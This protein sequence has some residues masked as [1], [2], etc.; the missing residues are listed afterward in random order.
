MAA[1]TED[2]G[3]A[4][5]IAAAL[6]L[7]ASVRPGG[8]PSPALKRRALHAARLYRAGLVDRIIASGGPPG[9]APSE[10]EVIRQLCLTA[11]VEEAHIHPEPLARNTEENIRF[12]LP[13]LAERRLA[14]A[15]LVTDRFHARRAEMVARAYGLTVLADCPGPTGAGRWQLLRLH[16]REAAARTAFRL[17]GKRG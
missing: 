5:P 14:L 11:G 12:A 6:V 3:K 8:Q 15:C 4:R 17:R 9:A 2:I 13:V 16:T 1:M 10:A 7:G